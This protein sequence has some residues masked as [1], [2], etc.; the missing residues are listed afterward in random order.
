MT[1]SEGAV[2]PAFS[3][4]AVLYRAPA[5]I[6]AGGASGSRCRDAE[7]RGHPGE[8]RVGQRGPFSSSN[9]PAEGESRARSRKIVCL[10]QPKFN[11][12]FLQNQLSARIP[13]L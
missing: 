13:L 3:G 5:R 7:N 2:C 9:T 11:F 10:K 12:F 8:N 1:Y 4:I 6:A